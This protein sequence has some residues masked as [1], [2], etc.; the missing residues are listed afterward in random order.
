L[1]AAE[2]VLLDGRR[3]YLL[4]D[5]ACALRLIRGYADLFAVPMAN[6]ASA[7]ARRHLCRTEAGGI[8]L[9]LPMVPADRGGHSV[10]VLAV[11]GHSAEALV[12]SRTLVDNRKDLECWLTGLGAA[13]ADTEPAWNVRLA[14][15]GT[16][17]Q[18]EP[19]QQF[20]APTHGVTWIAVKDGE[21]A[22]MGG[23]SMCRVGDFAM[24]F[25]PG[26]W[27][28][29][30]GNTT[31]HILDGAEVLDA[32][33]WPAVDAFH[34]FAMRCIANRMTAARDRDF[35][36]MR[37]STRRANL[38]GGQMVSELAAILVPRRGAGFH[39]E[40]ADPLLEA[41]RI[42]A[43]AIGAQVTAPA[44]RGSSQ[45][46]DDAADIARA[47]HLRARRVLLRMDWWQSDVGPFVAW[48]WELLNPVAIIPVS[49]HRYVLVEPRNNT[50]CPVDGKIA[51]E[52]APE[53]IMFYAPLPT[54]VHSSGDLVKFCLQHGA[55]EI[56]RILF[57]A[58]AM[59]LLALTTPLIT[60]VLI[61]SV[62]PRTEWDQL[63]YCAVGLFMVAIGVAGFKTMQGVSIL[64]LEGQVSRILQAG[65]VDRLLNLPVSFFRHY[66]AGDMTDRALGVDAIR[67]VATGHAIQG[68]L[69]GIFALFSFALMFHY[70]VRLALIAGG[71]TALRGAMV[72]IFCV[73]RLR[74]ERQHF[75]LAG[76]A[77]ALVLQLITGVAKLR[78][79]FATQRAL[80]VWAHKFAAQ[81]RQ[82]VASQRLANLVS[83]F[84]AAFPPAAMLLVFA[85]VWSGTSHLMLDTGQFLAFF[86]AFGQT[87]V[88]G[89]QVVAAASA[90]VITVPLTDRLRPLVAQQAEMQESRNAPGEL[91]GSIEIGQVTFRY[92][93]GGPAVLDKLTMQVGRGEYLALVGPSGCG[94]S[95]LFRL[96][97]GFEKPESGAILFDGK[98]IDSLDISSVRRQFGVVLQNGKLAS[99]N[100]YENICGGAPL[101]LER[102]WEAARL[103]GLED[104]ILAMPMGM[105]TTIAEGTNTLSGGQRQRLMIARALVHHPRILLFDEATSALDNRTQAIVSASLAKLNVTRI[106]I[107]QRL[108][109]VKS[110]D[111]IIV[112]S[113]GKIVQ[114]GTFEELSA[115]PGMFAEFAKRQLL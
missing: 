29:A 78:V 73:L 49:S 84:E 27:G 50:T 109:T 101:P 96:L 69:A 21:V 113:G 70:S 15:S 66:P 51:A 65:I 93:T 13:L 16:V 35:E 52:L 41:C 37:Q 32:D 97:L 36:R 3:P 12:I 38:Q 105:H 34:E 28:E 14:E 47:S 58:V 4:D 60:E 107:A 45:G 56:I 68:L 44:R 115:V 57:S 106:V 53:A 42:A 71:L 43:E 8:I 89:S 82:F 92:A 77:Q 30:R 104:D 20:C 22:L 108:S 64:R 6:G 111:R 62:I 110:A 63:I 10:G 11:G 18:L 88:A 76:K 79:A 99:G 91:T 72:G 1:K 46:I 7:G 85:G 98:L 54:S 9:G 102:A 55:A 26:M 5:T 74:R 19:G 40:G 103:A 80:A 2:A 17:V 81:K 61:D 67:R 75:E 25:V 24:P 31:V 48:H 23:T 83:V 112:L 90:A 33:P 114:S 59:G 100:L 94:K 86:V 39:M 87:L 95:T